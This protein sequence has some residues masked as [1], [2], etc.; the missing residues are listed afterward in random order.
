MA[1]SSPVGIPRLGMTEEALSLTNSKPNSAI[2]LGAFVGHFIAPGLVQTSV[3]LKEQVY[4]SL[5]A[6]TASMLKGWSFLRKG[7][8]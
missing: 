1:L 4:S 3:S 2:S 6:S 8:Y 5:S 7:L